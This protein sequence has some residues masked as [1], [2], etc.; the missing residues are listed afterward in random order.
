[1]KYFLPIL[2]VL[3]TYSFSASAQETAK[4][5]TDTEVVR[6]VALMVI[7]GVNY[8]NVVVSMICITPDYFFTDKYKVKMT[9]ADEYGKTIYKKTFKNVFLFVFPSGQIQVGKNNFNQVVIFKAPYSNNY[10]GE[11]NEKEGVF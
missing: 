3:F 6:K 1:M 2:F 7:E 10:Y 4:P 11:V 9:V 5:L 8:K